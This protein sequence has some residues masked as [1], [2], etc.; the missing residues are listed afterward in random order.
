MHAGRLRWCRGRQARVQSIRSRAWIA[1]VAVGVLVASAAARWRFYRPKA[2]LAAQVS[3]VRARAEQ[4][5]AEAEAKLGTIY[6]LGRGVPQNHAEAL[7]WYRKSAE[8]GSPSGEAGM[9]TA[10]YYGYG[11]PP[12]YAE[13]MR[14]Y[15]KAADQGNAAGET[16]VGYL[17]E[18]GD[19]VVQDYTEALRWYR[20]AADQGGKLAERQLGDMNYYGQGLLQDSSQAVQWYRKAAN[21]GEARAAY[22]LGYMY[23]YGKGVLQNRAEANRW[24]VKAADAGDTN[25]ERWLTCPLTTGIKFTLMA[26]FALGTLLLSFVPMR[27]SY[28]AAP[29]V[30]WN[31]NRLATVTAG[32]LCLVHVGVNWYGYTHALLRRYGMPLNPFTWLYR[33]IDLMMF[34]A[35][36]YMVR[37]AFADRQAKSEF[38]PLATR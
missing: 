15:R 5:D 16:G 36:A 27:L 23:F 26:E 22:D 9:G 2:R 14:W 13:S 21:Q 18:H 34:A 24:F 29:R 8:Q 32:L 35:L 38:E 7:K 10:F 4:G 25:A 11:V 30:G 28:L 17:Y 31:R 1:T 6:L 3:A 19:G 12:D 37:I 20:K 33:A